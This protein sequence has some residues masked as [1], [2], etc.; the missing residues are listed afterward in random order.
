MP[1]LGGCCL[2]TTKPNQNEDTTPSVPANLKQECPPLDKWKDGTFGTILQ[3]D[4]DTSTKY[5]ECRNKHK[6]L[7]DAVN[8]QK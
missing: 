2:T 4:L 6:E 3:H 5:A 1:L 8:K 7:V